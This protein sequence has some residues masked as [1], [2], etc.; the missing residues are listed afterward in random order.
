MGKK[1]LSIGAGTVAL[2]LVPLIA[3]QF[4]NEVNWTGRDFAAM[5]VLILVSGF[6]L[7][8][9]WRKAGKY[10]VGALIAVVA[11]FFYLWAELAVGIFTNW[12]S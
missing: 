1:I 12:G 3:M 6:L 11:L 7:D 5:G 10:R 9:A 4:T 8:L 2:L